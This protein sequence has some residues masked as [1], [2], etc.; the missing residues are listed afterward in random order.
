MPHHSVPGSDAEDAR[1][2]R[3]QS[4]IFLEWLGRLH[5]KGET[6]NSPKDG[7]YSEV[8]ERMIA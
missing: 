2:Q 1:A 4:V 5:G 6:K 7:S 8:G 3:R